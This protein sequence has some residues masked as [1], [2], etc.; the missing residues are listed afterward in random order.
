MEL[1]KEDFEQILS[2]QLRKTETKL[3]TYIKE[4]VDG[5]ARMVA[6]GFDEVQKRLDVTEELKQHGER[7]AKL[8]QQMVDLRGALHLSA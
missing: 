8:E 6:E 5:L 2:H 4:E 7:V 3:E 1:T